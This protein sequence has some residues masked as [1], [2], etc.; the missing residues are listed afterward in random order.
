M[1]LQ[2]I[3]EGVPLYLWVMYNFLV[4]LLPETE[5]FDRKCCPYCFSLSK[6]IPYIYVGFCVNIIIQ[7]I[8]HLFSKRVYRR[9]VTILNSGTAAMH[10]QIKYLCYLFLLFNYFLFIVLFQSK[11]RQS[12]CVPINILCA[13]H[14]RCSVCGMINIS[15]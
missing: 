9:N 13:Y 3:K 4:K 8:V 5:R 7:H 14:D 2:M 11:T 1:F 15:G 10:F 6:Y 12:Q